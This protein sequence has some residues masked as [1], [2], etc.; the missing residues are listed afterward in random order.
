MRI[1]VLIPGHLRPWDACKQNFLDTLYDTNHQIDVFVETYNSIFR[2][3]GQIGGESELKYI[4]SR[5]DVLSLFDGI[6]VV[7]CN[8]ET[9][10]T[11]DAELLQIRKMNILYHSFQKYEFENG[12]YDLVVRSRFDILLDKTIDYNYIYSLCHDSKN[13]FIGKGGVHL[14]ENDLFAVSNSHLMRL[15][16]N[17]I[18]DLYSLSVNR[19]LEINKN[20][21]NKDILIKVYTKEEKSIKSNTKPIKRW[22]YG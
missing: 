10:L 14:A 19:M 2:S 9:D 4:L 21:S 8:V 13:M 6:N 5:D 18:H 1:A 7:Y 16:F 12:P 3:D 22:S 20:N 15:Y 17:C 11:G